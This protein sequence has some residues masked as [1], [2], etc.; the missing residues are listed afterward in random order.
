M[1]EGA[2]ALK[3]TGV[4]IECVPAGCWVRIDTISR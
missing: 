1:Q 4:L 3:R 2:L